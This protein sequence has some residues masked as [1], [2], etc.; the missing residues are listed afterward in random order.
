MSDL[1][2]H[3]ILQGL[4]FGREIYSIEIHGNGR[5][6][7]VGIVREDDGPCCIVFRGPLVTEGGRRLIRARGTM[8]WPK[9]GRDNE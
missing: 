4:D 3:P 1:A 2:N 9:E 5:G 8:A 6:D 7:Y